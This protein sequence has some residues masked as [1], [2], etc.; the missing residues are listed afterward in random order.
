MSDILNRWD[1]NADTPLH[2]ASYSGQYE[3]ARMM[4]KKGAD[5]DSMNKDR[6]TPLHH[7]CAGNFQKIAVL[8]I[9]KYV[10]I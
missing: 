10:E 7:A 8:F 4:V 2:I 9:E 6:L 5:L 3:I 1:R